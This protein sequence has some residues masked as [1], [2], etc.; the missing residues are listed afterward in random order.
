MPVI[1]NKFVQNAWKKDLC[2][3]CFKSLE[4]HQ[5]V[6]KETVKEAAPCHQELSGQDSL[7]E[8]EQGSNRY[9]TLTNGG[10]GLKSHSYSQQISK[11][12]DTVLDHSSGSVTRSD[13]QQ[14]SADPLSYEQQQDKLED[15]MKDTGS[16]TVIERLDSLVLGTPLSSLEADSSQASSMS[17]SSIKSGILKDANRDRSSPDKKRGITF[18]DYEELQV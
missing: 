16:H 15:T 10:Y 3:N 7:T 6:S 1:C 4:D 12:N 9:Q 8:L 18:P 14:H 2:S 11:W 13:L 17:S 5:G